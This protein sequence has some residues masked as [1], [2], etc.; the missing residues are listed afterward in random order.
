[1][2]ILRRGITGITNSRQETPEP[3]FTDP[4]LTFIEFKSLVYCVAIT[5]NFSVSKLSDCET[6][7]LGH[8][9][10]NFYTASLEAS[11][12][13]VVVLCNKI[14]P[15]VAFSSLPKFYGQKLEFIDIPPISSLI[16]GFYTDIAVADVDEL[17]R[18]FDEYDLMVLGKREV[19]EIMDQQK[20]SRTKTISIGE[21]IFNC[22]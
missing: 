3:K 10:P 2:T 8:Y 11:D 16:E 15:V 20:N 5:L 6:L 13:S 4:R 19:E 18:M 14:Y 22:W 12:N 1:M 9:F 7:G 17:N 21:I